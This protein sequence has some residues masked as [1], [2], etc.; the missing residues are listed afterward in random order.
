MKFVFCLYDLNYTDDFLRSWVN[1][2]HLIN[3]KKFIPIYV[4]PEAKVIHRKPIHLK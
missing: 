1:L 2:C 4:H 3:S